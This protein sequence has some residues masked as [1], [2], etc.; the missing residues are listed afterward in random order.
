[1]RNI[2]DIKFKAKCI[3][4]PFLRESYGLWVFG[5]LEVIGDRAW[6]RL[7]DKD[8]T[9]EEILTYGLRQVEV[10]P[11][12]VCQYTGYQ[13]GSGVDIYEKDVLE[14]DEKS[15]YRVEWGGDGWL[16]IQICDDWNIDQA[17]SLEPELQP[18]MSYFYKG[19]KVVGHDNIIGETESWH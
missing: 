19:M 11:E 5:N 13:D 3:D 10:E 6:I 12:S 2:K 8:M 4:S 9:E 1:M 16:L 17:T 18:R 14:D 7:P 15:L